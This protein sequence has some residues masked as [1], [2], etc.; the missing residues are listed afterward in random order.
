MAEEELR[1]LAEGSGGA[2]YREEDLH[3]LP[4]AIAPRFAP[5]SERREILLWNGWMLLALVGLLT[6]EW[7]GRKYRNLS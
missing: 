6:V 4:D 1:R 7:V 3:R 5:Y 2:F